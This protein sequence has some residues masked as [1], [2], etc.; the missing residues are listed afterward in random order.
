MRRSTV[1]SLTAIGV[2]SAG[3]CLARRTLAA[4][5][6][7]LPPAQHAVAVERNIRVPM[8]DGVTLYADRY[9]PRASG[10]FPT[11]LVRTPYGRP[12]ELR[13]LGPFA[14]LIAR[15]FAGQG[16]N[17][18]V[19]GV[20]GR[21]RSGGTFEPFVHET[22]DGRAT[23]EWIASQPW[24][25]G[26]LGMW[27]VSYPGY[28]QWAVALDAPPYLKALTPVVITARFSRAVYPHGAF[29]FESSL[30]W[31]SLLRATHRPGGDLDLGTAISLLSP[32]REAALTGVMAAYSMGEADRAAIGE[33]VSF[34][35]RWL[36]DPDPHGAYWRQVDLHRTLG[37]ITVPVHLV[38]GWHD[39]FLS[40]QLADYTTLL[41]AGRTP[42]LTVL[43]RHHNDPAL[44]LDAV[45]EGLWWFDVQLKGRRERLRRR[46]VRLALMGSHEWHE[47]DYWPPPAAMTRYYL[48]AEGLLSTHPPAASSAPDRYCYNP[49][50]PT[51]SIGGPTLGP[52]GGPRDQRPIEGRGDVLC[53]TTPPLH[54][55]VDVIGYVRLELYARSSLPYTDFVGRVCDV[56]PDG[57]SINVCE[58]LCRITPGVGE[59]QADG[60]LRL[61]LDL[62]ATAQR[63]RQGHRI[64]VH[65]C[66]AAHPRWGANPG[67]GR[68]FRDAGAVPGPAAEQ[69]IYHD[70]DHPSA[71][72]LPVVS[73]TTRRAMEGDGEA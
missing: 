15:L 34:Y 41:A 5:V 40:D 49:R 1:L 26:N 69:T 45:R 8:P 60:S 10:R 4:R 6:L 56:Y 71:L 35:Q 27:G 21:Y 65:V 18:V 63:F 19:Q 23:L 11:I 53:Y 42:Y 2:A 72:V 24:F 32:R 31:A 62:G 59:P 70:V 47:M 51:P 67:D 57:R 58:G 9:L 20:R 3:A 38:A 29:A 73:A 13:A 37:R 25:D 16:Y 28:T 22:A 12:S 61:D 17:V 48:H 66:S 46:P 30:R 64:R 68:R 54:A 39:L 52:R 55:E 14:G 44:A 43:P 36:D 50:D 33:P 7:G